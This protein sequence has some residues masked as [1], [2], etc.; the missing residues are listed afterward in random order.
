MR[1]YALASLARLGIE[2]IDLWYPHFPDPEVPIEDTV[3]AMVDVVA[4]GLVAHIGLSNV[5]AEQ[6]RRACAVHPVAAVQVEWS[7]WKPIDPELLAVAGEHDVGIVAWSPL[8]GGFLTG[9]VIDIAEDD[10]R[11]NFDRFS[12]E[13]LASQ[14]RAVQPLRARG[15]RNSGSRLASSR[16]PGFF[17]SIPSGRAHPRQPPTGAHRREPGCGSDRAVG[18]RPGRQID[19]ALAAFIPAGRALM[20][21][22][23]ISRSTQRWKWC[24]DG[25]FRPNT[26][27]WLAPESS[28]RVMPK[29]GGVVLVAD[30]REE[31]VDRLLGSLPLLGGDGRMPGDEGLRQSGTDRASA[32]GTAGRRARCHASARRATGTGRSCAPVRCGRSAATPPPPGRGGMGRVCLANMIRWCGPIRVHRHQVAHVVLEDRVLVER[33]EVVALQVAVEGDL[34]RGARQLTPGVDVPRVELERRQLG[35]VVAEPVVD[36]HGFARVSG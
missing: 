28:A 9:S 15:Q 35:R 26:N 7:L 21:S 23:A 16:S 36:V 1:Q 24:S 27:S 17:T 18:R 2:R 11:T 34:P 19:D 14:Q 8:G 22:Q 12:P 30:D 5:T 29:P 4:E 6:L 32:R 3:G 20:S 31:E 10:F 33:R 13:H 25:S